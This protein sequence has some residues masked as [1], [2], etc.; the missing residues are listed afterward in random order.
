MKNVLYIGG[1][2]L[3][4][5]NAA[6]QR[7]IANG[8]L[9]VKAGY[10]VHYI[11]VEL[12]K[13]IEDIFLEKEYEGFKYFVKS[14]KYPQT[15][16]EWFSFITSIEF[17]KKA[18]EVNLSFLPD[19][20]VVYNYPAVSLLKLIKYCKNNNI[21]LIADITEWYFPDGSLFFKII[22]GLDAYY[23]MNFLHKKLDG[24]IVIS[25]YLE[26]FYRDVNL[27][28]LPPLVDKKSEKWNC[29]HT[30]KSDLRTLI[31]VGSISHGQK[32]RLDIIINSL[33]QINV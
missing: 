29:L 19:I 15:K 23:R 12:N 5:K 6:A 22:K 26:D 7:V 4:D 3:P 14:Q 31:Y 2:K 11:D 13:S 16:Q 28:R 1:F 18:I 27:I 9:F 20:I 17:V 21:K 33:N 10:N 32:D 25:K 30:I 8:K 24:V